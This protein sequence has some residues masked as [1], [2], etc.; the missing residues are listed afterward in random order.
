[1]D[2]IEIEAVGTGT[3]TVKLFNAR[4]GEAKVKVKVGNR[5]PVADAGVDK[6]ISILNDGKTVT[7]NGKGSF[8]P[9]GDILLYSWELDQS[10]V[11]GKK[12]NLI[13]DNSS[14]AAFDAYGTGTYTVKL[15]VDDGIERSGTDTATITV[16]P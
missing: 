5:P 7:L 8:D 3:A 1:M 2:I 6:S 12:A 13:N 4:G 16:T 15:I 11:I 9:D 14:I 10:L